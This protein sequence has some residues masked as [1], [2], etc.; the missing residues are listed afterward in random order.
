MSALKSADAGKYDTLLLPRGVMNPDHLCQDQNAVQFV[1]AFFYAHKPVAAICH[2]P[3]ILVEAGVLRGRKLTSWP[4]L[5]TDIKNA[6]GN[7]VDQEVVA[8]QGLVTSRN[9]TTS[10]PSTKR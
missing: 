2:R 7:W 10:P 4:S 3:W 6:G 9:R 1:K 5:K 8:D